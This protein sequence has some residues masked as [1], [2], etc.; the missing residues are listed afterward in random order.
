MTTTRPPVFPPRMVEHQ[1][2]DEPSA[3]SWR[4]PDQSLRGALAGAEAAVGSWLMVTVLTVTGYVATAAAPALGAATWVDA[5][6][7]GSTLWLLGHGATATAGAATIS[8]IPLGI[9]MISVVAAATAI[10]RARMTTWW[11]LLAT[12]VSY[13]VLTAVLAAWVGG[14]GSWWALLGALVVVSVG[15][16][17]AMRH[18]LPDP[19]ARWWELIPEPVRVGA[20]TGLRAAGCYLLLGVVMVV[21]AVV[22]GFD[23]VAQ[24]H[25]ALV[26][27]AVSTVLIVV[28][29]VLALPT[30][31]VWAMAYLAGPGFAVGQGTLFS[32]TAVDA[33]PLPL[34]PVLGALPEPGSSHPSLAAIMVCGVLLGAV[35][36]LWLRRRHPTELKD[37]LITVA[38]A[39][40]V[41][42]LVVLVLGWASSGAV[43]PGRM[44]RLG[45][46]PLALMLAVS[47]QLLLGMGMTAILAHPGLMAGLRGAG[48]SGLEWVRQVGQR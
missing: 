4:L 33:G 44:S 10:R 20:A 39:V 22:L 15:G 46:M 30:V 26:P 42:G 12:T 11:A 16:A 24:V 25:R 29:Q 23:Q 47:W 7:L 6:R 13:L 3:S 34:I 45:P 21:V 14:L 36:G 37:T 41:A 31:A 38:V 5:A 27:D 18:R 2:D 48:R 9:T 28:A 19:I 40:A 8:I 1:E 35:C 17:W 32:A 43:G